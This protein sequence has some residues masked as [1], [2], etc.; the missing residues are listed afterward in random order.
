MQVHLNRLFENVL[1]NFISI[2]HENIKGGGGGGGIK[3]DYLLDRLH[4]LHPVTRDSRFIFSL[5]DSL[6]HSHAVK[7]FLSRTFSLSLYLSQSLSHTISLS[8]TYTHSLSIYLTNTLSIYLS[9]THTQSMTYPL[10]IS[11]ILYISLT[12][13]LPL[14]LSHSQYIYLFQPPPQASC[15]TYVLEFLQTSTFHL[16]FLILRYSLIKY[17]GRWSCITRYVESMRD[18][19]KI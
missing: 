14:F 1:R 7:A 17:H 4:Y 9:H 19:K 13:S 3:F 2:N 11:L 18:L 16:S 5:S 6:P 12:M 8:L 10:A 15:A